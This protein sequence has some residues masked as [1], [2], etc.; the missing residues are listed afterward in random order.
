MTLHLQ[1]TRI[2]TSVGTLHPLVGAKGLC[3]L[4]WGDRFERT[5]AHLTRHI[6][7]W[8]AEQVDHIPDV[9]SHL[10]AYFNGDLSALERI[11]L[12]LN[13]TDFQLKVWTALREIPIGQTR[14]YGQL[15]Q[16]I[17]HPKAYRAVAQANAHNPIPLVVPC[18]RVIAADG[19]IGGF[20]CGID[21]KYWLLQHEGS[22]HQTDLLAHTA[23]RSQ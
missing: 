6:G 21:R 8:E 17:G 9:T 20:S 7:K 19:G 22:W 16:S 15:A 12:D 18:H 14:S 23:R 2:E 10:N 1:Q 11:P 3:A 5:E 4:F 13:G